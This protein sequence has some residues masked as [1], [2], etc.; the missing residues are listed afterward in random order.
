VEDDHV[1][2]HPTYTHYIEYNGQRKS[3]YRLKPYRITATDKTYST[4]IQMSD[5]SDQF[6]ARPEQATTCSGFTSRAE[7]DLTPTTR[8]PGLG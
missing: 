1:Y 7:G 5:S 6:L 4:Y 3:Y 2:R 8:G